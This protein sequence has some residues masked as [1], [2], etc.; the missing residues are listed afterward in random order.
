MGDVRSVRRCFSG[1]CQDSPVVIIIALPKM[2]ILAKNTELPLKE[3][4][5]VGSFER[6]EPFHADKSGMYES[7]KC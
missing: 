6:A 3:A 7:G 5:E 2:V 1:C 4:K